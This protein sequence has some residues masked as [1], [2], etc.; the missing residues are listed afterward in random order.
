MA[1]R[2]EEERID[3]TTNMTGRDDKMTGRA[4]DEEAHI[5]VVEE[6]L[7][8]GKRTVETGGVRVQK[9]VTARSVEEDI[10]LHEERVT[11]SAGR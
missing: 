4:R 5:P 8:I 10:N 6:E 9:E 3:Q 11:A 1:H 2:N 7:A